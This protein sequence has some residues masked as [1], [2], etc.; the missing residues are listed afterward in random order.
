MQIMQR[1]KIRY[2]GAIGFI[3]DDEDTETHAVQLMMND[4][5]TIKDMYLFHTYN[6]SLAPKNGTKQPVVEVVISEAGHN[7]YEFIRI[8]PDCYVILEEGGTVTKIQEDDWKTRIEPIKQW[9]H[10]NFYSQFV[11]PF[12]EFMRKDDFAAE[13][14]KMILNNGSNT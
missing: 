4:I 7:W 13:Y 2:P 11:D 3:I 14:Q 5:Y 8:P 10:A 1:V 6:Q 9:E 12:L